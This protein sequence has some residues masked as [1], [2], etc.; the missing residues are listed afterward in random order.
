MYNGEAAM[1]ISAGISKQADEIKGVSKA[2]HF[3]KSAYIW[4]AI[5]VSQGQENQFV[6]FRLHSRVRDFSL[7]MDRVRPG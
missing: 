3:K 2:M 6:T 4:T 1:L 7:G 5:V